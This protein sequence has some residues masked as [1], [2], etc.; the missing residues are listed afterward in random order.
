M[1][2]IAALSFF[3]AMSTSVAVAANP[4]TAVVE[5]SMGNMKLELYP[6]KA[7]ATVQNFVNY[8]KK[9]FYDG[10]IFHRVIDG[11]MI[12]CGGFTP[13][14]KEKPTDAKIKNES[15]NGLTNDMYT[16]AMARTPDPH[17]ATS[18]FFINTSNQ[19]GFL[20][21]ASARDGWGYCVFGKV[22][23]GTDVVNKISK[24]QTGN[25][26]PHGDVPLKPIVITNVTI[27]E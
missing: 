7:P 23:D 20:N 9:G 21:R 1:R 2:T 11:F 27:V 15:A 19:N 25:A 13:D 24:V 26:G 5:T 3:A 14:M 8:A 10:T 12:Q 18:Q 4:V 22:V 17:S 16:L 6:D